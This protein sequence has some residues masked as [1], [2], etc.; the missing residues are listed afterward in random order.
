MKICNRNYSENSML[1]V[2]KINGVACCAS[3][4][5]P[6]VAHNESVGNR[7]LL[8]YMMDDRGISS[9]AIAKHMT[10]VKVEG[11]FG[12]QPPSDADD[13]GRCIRLL[14]LIP[15]WIPRLKE[16]TIYDKGGNNGIVISSSGIKANT[17]S[18]ERQIPMILKEGKF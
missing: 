3:C 7:T 1:T 14:E 4:E 11:I 16:M 15:E 8:W 6:T 5:K 10:G 17:N 13:R 18:W 2:K 9:N 12:M